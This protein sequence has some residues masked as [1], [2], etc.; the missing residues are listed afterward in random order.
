MAHQVKGSNIVIEAAQVT[1]VVQVRSLAW[2]LLHVAGV[3]QNKQISILI[4]KEIRFVVTR[5]RA[6]GAG[7][8][9]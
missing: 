5:G 6:W 1:A 9:K 4:E 7:E 8:I 2:E 3:A